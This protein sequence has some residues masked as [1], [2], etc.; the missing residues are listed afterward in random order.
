MIKK[1]ILPLVI[2]I[3]FGCSDKRKLRDSWVVRDSDCVTT[4]YDGAVFAFRKDEVSI[5]TNNGGQTVDYYIQ[6]DTI[7]LV[8]SFGIR[9]YYR[10]ESI[11]HHELELFVLEENCT[12]YLQ[13]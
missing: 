12:L 2:L 4:L 5:S 13:D 11:T 8:F 3:C 7:N 6:N 9:A 10:I 1:I